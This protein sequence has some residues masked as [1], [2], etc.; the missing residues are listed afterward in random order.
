MK[1]KFLYQQKFKINAK[2]FF[3]HWCLPIGEMYDSIAG[4]AIN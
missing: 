2:V 1:S 4:G 3:L